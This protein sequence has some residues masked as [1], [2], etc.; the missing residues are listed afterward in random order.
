M[1]KKNKKHLE[2]FETNFSNLFKIILTIEFIEKNEKY[3]VE[4]K[5]FKIK[6]ES[7]NSNIDDAK[8][9]FADVFLL[10]VKDLINRQRLF[11]VMQYLGFKQKPYSEII[12]EKKIELLTA[13]KKPNII[14]VDQDK[15]MKESFININRI[16]PSIHWNAE[17]L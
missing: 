6:I 5:K 14:S 9:E 16:D 3:I 4:S 13:M 15:L 11:H 10:V 7:T 12:E 2:I 8:K 1:N 17:Q